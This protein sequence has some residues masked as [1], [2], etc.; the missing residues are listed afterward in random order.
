MFKKIERSLALQFTGF[1]FLLLM[2]NGAVF[3]IIDFGNEIRQMHARLQNQMSLIQTA[4]PDIFMGKTD[5]LFLPHV[6]RLRVVNQNGES[7]FS[8]EL[9]EDLP[10]VQ[11]EGFSSAVIG[12]EEFSLLTETMVENGETVGYVQI[13]EPEFAVMRNLQ[14]RFL[15]YM[16]VSILISLLTYLFGRRFA[17]KSLRPAEAMLIRLE[18]FTQDASHELRTPLAVLGSTLD[19]ALKTKR[20][21]EGIL[22]AKEDLKQISALVERLLELARAGHFA[23]E[24]SSLDLSSLVK[25]SLL[26][27]KPLAKSAS[28]TLLSNIEPHVLVFA[29]SVL[30]QQVLSNLLSNGIKFTKAGGTV[31][32][33][34]TRHSLA[35]ADTGIGISAEHLPHMY[36]R[37]YRADSSRSTK[38]FGLGLSFVKQIVDMHGWT[39][40]VESKEGKGTTFTVLFD[41]EKHRNS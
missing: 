6:E 29:D 14:L 9:F 1:V 27:F 22:S 36:E 33:S 15:L 31:E 37:F 7:I 8:G 17:K 4:L 25:E 30:L 16:L 40:L 21:E 35:V 19:L 32:V 39:I 10:F 2:V 41:S 12:Q 11:T 38:G 26:K 23:L 13:A 3:L 5:E 34:L 18:Q 20:C 24:R 28:I